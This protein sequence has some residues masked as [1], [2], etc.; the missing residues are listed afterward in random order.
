MKTIFWDWNGTLLNDVEMCVSCINKLLQKRQLPQ[1]D[2]NR[3]R[4]VFTFPVKTYYEQI[5]FDFSREPFE[6]PAHE[7]MTLYHRHL[8][9]TPL[10]DYAEETLTH[11]KQRGDQ[12]LV[13]S[14]MEH[15]SLIKTLNERK[16][17]GYFNAVSGIDNIFAEGKIGMA[18]EF[19]D[20]LDIR[21]ED[22]ILIGDSLHD[23]EV[24]MDLGIEHILVA[25]GHQSK[26]RLIKVSSHVAD[27]LKEVP[28]MI[29]KWEQ[30]K[31]F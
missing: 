2:V 10:F 9:E 27:T 19:F 24:A 22:A 6:T 26:A 13:L 18:R 25:S 29:E 14:A 11:F 7:F 1:L 23:W 4:E 20:Q 30:Y 16:L 17:N 31:T 12:Q 15:T 3:Y 28:A 8:P 21:K 5:G